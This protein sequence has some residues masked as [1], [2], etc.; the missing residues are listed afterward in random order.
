[1]KKYQNVSYTELL[2]Y[3]ENNPNRTSALE[4]IEIY[5]PQDTSLDIIGLKG[6]KS[7]NLNPSGMLSLIVCINDPTY[8][9]IASSS[10]R[11]QS[12][13]DITTK[14]QQQTE[15]LKN[16]HMSRKRKKIS[17][18]ISAVY[19]GSK[20]EEKDYFDL[21][22]GFSVLCNIQFILIKSSIQEN[23]EE[24]T[25][26]N[27]L[28]GEIIFSSHPI[29]WKIDVPVW[30]VDSHARWIAISDKSVHKMIGVWL[31]D[32]EHTG[33]IVKWPEVDITK[34]EM[35]EQL[36]QFPTWNETDRKLTKDILNVRLGRANCIKV[37]TSWMS[38]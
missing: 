22:Q 28:K 21:F 4:S 20:L 35:V 27:G 8:Y 9:S 13:M 3:S 1:M 19:N 2:S 29:N 37:F 12:I 32:I 15:E 34:T 30:I 26:N 38:S 31:N 36:S 16:T 18:L 5:K 24:G 17:E 25:T 6:Y 7:I 14:L 33:W 11:F 23:I 10:A